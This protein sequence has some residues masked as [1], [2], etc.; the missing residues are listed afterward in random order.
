[1]MEERKKKA[2]A[3]FS[4][5]ELL[6]VLV[7]IMILVGIIVGAA[8][9][10]Q[11]KAAISSTQSEIAAI[12]TALESY[13]NDNGAY[14]LTGTNRPAD[15]TQLTYTNAQVLYSALAGGPGYP[16]TYLTFKANQIRFVSATQTN[17]V[18]SFGNVLSYYC[19]PGAADQTNST[20]FDLWS[21]GPNNKNDEGTNDDITNWR[22]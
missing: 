11:Q 16:K 21:Y 10:A 9:Y 13:H 22:Q 20:T 1:M 3:G 2:E 5:I 17:I 4:L 15:T 8:K 14:P 6:T 18:D 19:Y 12:S 7:I